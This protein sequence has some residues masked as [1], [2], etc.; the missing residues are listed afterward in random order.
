MVWYIILLCTSQ[1]DKGKIDPSHDNIHI[2][3]YPYIYMFPSPKVSSFTMIKRSI[4]SDG[5]S[6]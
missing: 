3:T 1:A 2:T 4:I 6:G 5:K